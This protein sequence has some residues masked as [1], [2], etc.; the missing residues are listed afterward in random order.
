[1]C[2]F[3]LHPITLSGMSIL[4]EISKLESTAISKILQIRDTNKYLDNLDLLNADIKNAFR[5][6]NTKLQQLEIIYEEQDFMDRKEFYAKKIEQHKRTLKKY[7]FVF[8]KLTSLYRLQNE[9]QKAIASYENKLSHLYREQRRQLLSGE[10]DHSKKKLTYRVSANKKSRLATESLKRTQ[11]YLTSGAIRA[12]DAVEAL[13]VSSNILSRTIHGQLDFG[14]GVDRSGK[15]L[16]ELKDRE[17]WNQMY[18]LLS[19]LFFCAVVV[20]ILLRRLRIPELL[21]FLS[22]VI[23]KIGALLG[24]I[25]GT[26]FGFDNVKNSTQV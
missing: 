12:G 8:S 6:I 15:T 3:T 4:E 5:Q 25:Q 13:E 18:I 17:W 1:M 26:I 24:W 14:A 2:E 7:E 19:F 23:A 21:R 16:K 20:Y 9:Y 10:P 22:L 11:A